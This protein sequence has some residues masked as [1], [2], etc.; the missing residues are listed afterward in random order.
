MKADCAHSRV[1]S[2]SDGFSNEVVLTKLQHVRDGFARFHPFQIYKDASTMHVLRM[3]RLACGLCA[4]QLIAA[5]GGGGGSAGSTPPMSGSPSQPS[6]PL[7]TFAANAT[8]LSFSAPIP[9]RTPDSQRVPVTFSGSTKSKLYV[10]ATTSNSAVSVSVGPVDQSGAAPTVD[11][12]VDPT[13]ATRLA[14]GTTSTTIMLTACIDDATCQ[15]GQP[16][17]GSPQTVNVTNTLNSAVQGD[18]IGPRVIPAGT[19]GTLYLRGRDLGNASQVSFGNTSATAVALGFD[20]DTEIRAS[21]PAL[22][23]GTYP[24]SINAGAIAFGASLVVVPAPSY[25][26]TTLTYPSVP[27]EIGGA[28]Y[29]AQRQ[30]FYVAAR[31]PGSQNNTLFKFRFSNGTWE[32]PISATVP[33][34]QDVALSADGSRVLALTDNAVVE[35][36]ADSFTSLGTTMPDDPLVRAG[37]AYMQ[38]LAVANDGYAIITTGGANPSTTLLYSSLAH[39]FFSINSA[40]SNLFGQSA[41]PQLYFGNVG[42]SANGAVLAISQDPRT[43]AVLTP[44]VDKPFMYFYFAV[45]QQRPSY[46]GAPASA[47]TDKDRSKGWRSARVAVNQIAGEV[48]GLRVIVNGAATILLRG[49]LDAHGLLPE[50]TRAAAIKSDASRAYVFVAANGAESG[51]LRSFDI[52]VDRRRTESFP[53]VGNGIALSVGAGTGAIAMTLTP[54]DGTVFVTGVNGVFVQPTKF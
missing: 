54:D 25:T 41:D 21:Y 20:A 52:S 43:A 50:E 23:A 19:P 42:A 34:L 10:I 49:D 18:L 6:G 9:N 31:Y 13:P 48:D 45:N 47:F 37:T 5:C 11:I 39:T 15:T 22:A 36:D 33:A 44:N 17:P 2:R 28:F 16:L 7:P 40:N 1:S 14:R 12:R 46:F 32:A 27:Q 29:D 26:A 24:V 3:A 30:A 8:S 51:E 38:N 35:F 53:Q 4:L